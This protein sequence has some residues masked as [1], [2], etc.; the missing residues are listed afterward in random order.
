MRKE[1]VPRSPGC[2]RIHR[3]S[4]GG[5]DPASCTENRAWTRS[6]FLSVTPNFDFQVL[7][8]MGDGRMSHFLQSS[9]IAN[10]ALIRCLF[11][12]VSSRIDFEALP[13]L[14]YGRTSRFLC[15]ANGVTQPLHLKVIGHPDSCTAVGKGR[16]RYVSLTI[17]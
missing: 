1:D 12:S 4:I 6:L 2:K 8:C 3:F 11:F 15:L 5:H 17:Y 10:R 13:C 16:K 7:S 9:Y 14:S